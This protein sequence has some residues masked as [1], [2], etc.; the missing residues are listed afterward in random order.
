MPLRN[1]RDVRDISKA[2]VFN[3]YEAPKLYVKLRCCVSCAIRNKKSRPVVV[4]SGRMEHAHPNLDLQVVLHDL[5]Q[6]T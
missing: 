2:S 1:S 3:A 5:H 4:E 6:T